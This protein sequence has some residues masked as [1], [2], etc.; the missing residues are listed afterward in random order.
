MN[1]QHA[2]VAYGTAAVKND[3]LRYRHCYS[4]PYLYDYLVLLE[5]LLPELLVDVEKTAVR[6]VH[7]LERRAL[8]Q[9]PTSQLPSEAA[10]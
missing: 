2:A 9:I 6:T 7:I 5:R 10:Q 1:S 8:L 4:R 3:P